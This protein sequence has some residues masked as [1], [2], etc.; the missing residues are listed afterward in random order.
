MINGRDN[1]V[2]KHREALIVLEFFHQATDLPRH[3]QALGGN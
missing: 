2:D 1:F 3:L